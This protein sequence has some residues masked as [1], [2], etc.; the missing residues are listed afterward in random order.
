MRNKEI[1]PMVIRDMVLVRIKL[2]R[3]YDETEYPSDVFVPM[4]ELFHRKQVKSF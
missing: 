2:L 3:D 4:N 1:P